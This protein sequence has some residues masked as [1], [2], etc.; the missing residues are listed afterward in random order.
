MASMTATLPT[1]PDRRP[2]L[3]DFL[4]FRRDQLQ[5]WLDT[6]R[7]GPAVQANFGGQ[8]FVVVTDPELTE[9]ILLTHVKDYPRDR[10]LMVHN[11]GGGPELMF[12]TDRWEEWKWRRRLLTPAFHRKVIDGLAPIMA[13]HADRMATEMLA[14]G[15]IDLQE[16]MR[17]MTMRIILETMFSVTRDDEVAKLQESFEFDSDLVAERTSSPVR[18]PAWLPT[19]AKRTRDAMMRYRFSTLM[20]VVTERMESGAEPA[21]LLDLL[22]GEHL[23]DDGRRFDADDLVGEMSGIVFAGH[24]TTAGTMTSLF[25]LLA[26]HPDVEARLL[27]ELGRVLGDRDPEMGDLTDLTYADQVIQETMRLYPPVYVTLREADADYTVGGIDLPTGT[28]FIIN[29]RG[30]HWDPTAW[31]HPERFDPDRFDPAVDHGRHRF[32][33]IPFLAGPKKCLGDTFAMTELRLVVPMLL[34][35]IRF[36]STGPRPEPT[37]GFTLSYPNGMPMQAAART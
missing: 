9:H 24:D 3:G 32:Q 22:I 10:R 6:G 37:A 23:E 28:R 11:R 16:R 31:D 13:R 33:F 12:N 27:D 36:T 19:K 14:A 4:A 5:F 20:G 15:S 35:R 34:R 1:R 2:V 30:L 18:I 26:E 21:D 17:T 8:H 29:I 25:A 7:L